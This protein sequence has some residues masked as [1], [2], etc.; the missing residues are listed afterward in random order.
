MRA[1][2]VA[3][4]YAKHVNP[5]YLNTEVIFEALHDGEQPEFLVYRNLANTIKTEYIKE[6]ELNAA[7]HGKLNKALMGFVWWNNSIN[8]ATIK[9]VIEI[10]PSFF[11]SFW[12]STINY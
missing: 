4:D 2:Q 11:I 8:K 12:A 1:V 7:D 3:V 9:V 5:K 10:L 6:T